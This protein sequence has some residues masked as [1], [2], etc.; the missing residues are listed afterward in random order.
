VSVRLVP[1]DRVRARNWRWHQLNRARRSRPRRSPRTIWLVDDDPGFRD[2]TAHVAREASIAVF[3]L[4]AEAFAAQP[5]LP[6]PDGAMLDGVV[7]SRAES[8]RFLIGVPRIV[9]CTGLEY[10]ELRARWTHHPHVRVLLKPFQLGDL[11]AALR[12]LAGDDEELGWQS[13]PP[14]SP[15]PRP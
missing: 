8:E 9:I 2:L 3:N 1:S 4:S 5:R 12:W 11:E 15:S 7:L 6:L 10:A 14:S 13:R